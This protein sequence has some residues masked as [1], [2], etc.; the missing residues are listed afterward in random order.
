MQMLSAKTSLSK[1]KLYQGLFRR[2]HGRPA[3]ARMRC[4]V[5]S[6]INELRLHLC[7]ERKN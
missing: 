7:K 1:N 5:H 6:C 4:V 3:C 2:V